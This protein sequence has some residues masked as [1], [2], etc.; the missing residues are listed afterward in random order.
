MRRPGL[1][2]P[3]MPGPAPRVGTAGWA[4]PRE[5]RDVFAPGDSNLARFGATLTAAEIV[6]C[7]RAPKGARPTR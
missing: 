2:P 3:R 1:T 5:V 4:L 6:A 7:R